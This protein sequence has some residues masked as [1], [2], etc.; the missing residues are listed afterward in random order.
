[1][2]ATGQF[3]VAKAPCTLH[4]VML[5]YFLWLYKNFLKIRLHLIFKVTWITVSETTQVR[6]TDQNI[7]KCHLPPSL[8]FLYIVFFLNALC[9]LLN[10]AITNTMASVRDRRDSSSS[11]FRLKAVKMTT[12]INLVYWYIH[13]EKAA[14][15]IVWII[16]TDR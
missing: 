16:Y 5:Y 12:S 8:L 13:H 3:Q 14:V 7:K 15:I 1:M 9:L 2:S 6:S 11:R 4:I 10:Y